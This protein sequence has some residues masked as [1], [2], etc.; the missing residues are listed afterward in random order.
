MTDAD[1]FRCIRV[2]DERRK[3]GR[4]KKELAPIGANFGKSAKKTA[5]IVGVSPRKVERARTILADSGFSKSKAQSYA[6]DFGKS[7]EVGGLK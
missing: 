7:N 2:L 5:E 6:F 3:A 4:P 1:I